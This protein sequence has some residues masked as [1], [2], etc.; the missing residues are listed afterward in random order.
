MVQTDLERLKEISG[1]LRK[2]FELMTFDEIEGGV[3]TD[4]DLK[5]GYSLDDEKRVTGLRFQGCRVKIILP[6]LVP[7]ERLVKLNL[8]RCELVDDDAFFLRLL[9]RLT[10]LDLAFNKFS[11]VSFLADFE[12]LTHLNLIGNRVTDLSF[13]KK[14]DNLS[15]IN[16]IFNPVEHPPQLIADK[17]LDAI[18][19]Y[20][21]NPF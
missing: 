18:R 17:G 13:V 15:R 12:A 16:I 8:W 3:I 5:Y 19:E 4:E 1:N 20:L 11:D 2:S 14:L 6:M 21:E 7:F 9:K 10:F